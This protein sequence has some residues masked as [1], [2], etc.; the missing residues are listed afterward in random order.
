MCEQDAV[1]L[2]LIGVV[3]VCLLYVWNSRY[4]RPSLKHIPVLGAELGKSARRAQMRDNARAFL[5]RGYREFNK[6][7]KPFQV[8]ITEGSMVV[9]N[10]QQTVEVGSMPDHIVDNMRPNG[11]VCKYVAR[12]ER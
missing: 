10:A 3:T 2:F 7:G 6:V 4:A 9:L 12:H 11:R 1:M 8:E 5:E